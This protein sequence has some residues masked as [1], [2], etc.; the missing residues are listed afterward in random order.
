V[1]IALSALCLAAASQGTMA[2]AGPGTGAWTV[3]TPESQG[4][5]SAALQAAAEEH[6]NSLNNRNCYVVVK[7]GNIVAEEYRN[8]HSVS[9]TRPGASTTKSSCA[10]LFG[11]AVE[12]GWA[13]VDDLVA[14][15]NSSQRR[16]H[17]DATFENVLTMTGQD[18]FYPEFIYDTLGNFCLDAIS[19]FIGENNPDGLSAVEWKDRYWQEALGMEHMSWTGLGGISILGSCGFGQD[20]S[21]RDLAR[22]GQL[23]LNDGAWDG[24]Q[25]ANEKFMKNSRIKTVGDYDYG[26]TLWL[27]PEDP[28]DPL[29]SSHRGAGGQCVYIS[30]EHEALVVT[31]GNDDCGN[32]WAVSR[33]AIVS[34]DHPRFAELEA[35]GALNITTNAA[36]F[37]DH[38]KELEE[39]LNN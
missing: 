15:M 2:Q 3:T 22:S 8:G 12:Q 19:D 1:R 28:V 31:M 36:T 23:F 33:G 27:E 39:Q 30:K 9:A 38:F 26:Y 6:L 11:I 32:A 29:V 14:E 34:N 18:L 13:S 5:S 37:A 20:I 25:L 7:N 10:A 21:C 17:P 35:S 16:C 4:L 24:K